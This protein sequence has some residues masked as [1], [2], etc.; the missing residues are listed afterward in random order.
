MGKICRSYGI[1]MMDNAPPG[2]ETP[3]ISAPVARRRQ[4]GA[5]CWRLAKAGPEVLLIT[6]RDTG[7]WIVPKGWAEKELGPARSALLEAWEEAGVR[8]RITD[9]PLGFFDYDKI[10][11]SG[12]RLPCRVDV[13][14]IEVSEV[15]K[16]FPEREQRR[17]RWFRPQKAARKVAE[18]GL[19]ALLAGFDSRQPS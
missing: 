18:P 12:A 5:I 15:A 13:Y 11:K 16:T 9:A 19:A 10:T 14:G 6:S 8:G 4:I 2:S 3:Q 7:R 17:R 1:E